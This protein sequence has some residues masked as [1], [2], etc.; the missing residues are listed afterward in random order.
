M[1]IISL[2]MWL[3]ISKLKEISFGFKYCFYSVLLIIVS[4]VCF[5]Y[6]QKGLTQLNCLLLLYV[7]VFLYNGIIGLLYRNR[8]FIIDVTIFVRA[9][10]FVLYNIYNIKPFATWF[11]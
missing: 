5:L 8:Y 10:R 7:R 11:K 4:T 3:Y 1:P 6:R 2:L 9:I